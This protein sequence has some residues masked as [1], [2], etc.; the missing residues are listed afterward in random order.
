MAARGTTIRTVPA[1]LKAITRL[2]DP[3]MFR[4]QAMYWPLLPSIGRLKRQVAHYENWQV[5]QQ[6]LVERFAK[7]ARP[8][9]DPLPV[10][11][12]EWLLHAQ[13][14][15]VPT[16]LLDWTTNPLKALFWAVE[17]QE[18]I[19]RDGIVWA[20]SPRYW[21]DDA[22][23]PTPLSDKNLTPFYPKH[24]NQRVVA[25]E[26]CF[27]SFPLPESKKA[28][29]SM[30]SG[31]AYHKAMDYLDKIVIPASAKRNLLRE[32][33]VLGVTHRSL[34]PDLHGIALHIEAEL[35]EA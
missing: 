25:Q 21:R 24:L 14:H 33:R 26:S 29:Q 28:L 4:G 6:D 5:F 2:S 23:D 18:Q 1:Y 16:R 31:A 34:F 17:G 22:L 30:D 7:Y 20:F 32:L 19:R 8:L 10:G 35:R 13:H 11:I 27:V 3:M 9:L 15:G 12:E